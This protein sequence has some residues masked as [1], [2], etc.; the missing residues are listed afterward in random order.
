MTF[1]DAEPKCGAGGTLVPEPP[2]LWGCECEA[3]D[4]SASVRTIDIGSVKVWQG[5]VRVLQH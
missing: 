5:T 3:G 4:D 2:D 1:K